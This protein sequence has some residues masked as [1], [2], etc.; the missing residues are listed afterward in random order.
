[1]STMSIKK[2]FLGLTVGNS[3]SRANFCV[4]VVHQ[5]ILMGSQKDIKFSLFM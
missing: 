3:N 1:M 5:V 4:K 2:Q